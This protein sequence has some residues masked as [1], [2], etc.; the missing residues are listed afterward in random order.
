MNLI[1]KMRKNKK[2]CVDFTINR[3]KDDF[4]RNILIIER[5]KGR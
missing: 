4:S 5:K 2:G 3:I 1:Y